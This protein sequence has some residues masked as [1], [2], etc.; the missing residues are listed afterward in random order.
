MHDRRSRLYAVVFV[1][2][3]AGYGWVLLARAFPQPD[4]LLSGA[5]LFK[6]ITT[7][8]CPSCGTTRAIV[9]LS[10]GNLLASLLLN[11]LGYLSAAIMLIA[12]LWILADLLTR[13]SS[14]YRFYLAAERL[15]RKKYIAIPAILLVLANWVWNV[16]KG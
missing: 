14:F 12:P 3:L 7:L 10:H 8:P 2:C 9:A 16:V 11:P 13:T 6:R 1:A 4:S 15:L 5:C